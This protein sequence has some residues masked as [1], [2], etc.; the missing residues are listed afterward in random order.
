MSAS[1]GELKLKKAREFK[2]QG[3]DFF[4]AEDFGKAMFQ[5][6]CGI[7]EVKAIISQNSKEL[8]GF[9]PSSAKIEVTVAEFQ[10]A[11]NLFVFLS[12][13]L[14]LCQLKLGKIDR[15][16]KSCTEALN[17]D[18]K[19]SKSLYRR[20]KAYLEKSEWRDLEKSRHDLEEAKRLS[21]DDKAIDS[22]LQHLTKLENEENQSMKKQYA[23]MFI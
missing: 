15:A 5:Y 1:T 14:A 13:N 6:H 17:V 3:N 2:D 16:I 20:G 9:V 22:L 4:K 21:P 19:H 7:L 8:K 18:P 23:K 11:E 10:E 12:S